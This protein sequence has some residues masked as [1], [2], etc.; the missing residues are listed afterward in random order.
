MNY[1]RGARYS[2]LDFGPL[3]F[4]WWPEGYPHS[5]RPYRLWVYLGTH[6]YRGFIKE[7]T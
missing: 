1:F 2:A 7:P 3:S 4:L 6:R 5:L